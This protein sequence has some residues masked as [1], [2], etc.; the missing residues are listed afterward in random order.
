MDLPL[1]THALVTRFSCLGAECPDTCCSGWDMPTDA[2]Q[3]ALYEVQAPELLATLDKATGGMKRAANGKDCA[4]LC[5]GHCAIQTRYGADFL[6]DSC[7]FYPRIV[8]TLGTTQRMTG[9]TSCPEMLRLMMD[10]K[11]P[12]ML[13]EITLKR[14]PGIR[15]DILPKGMSAAEA[16]TMMQEYMAIAQDDTA[17]PEDIM[18]RIIAKVSSR[19]VP[20]AT[21]ATLHPIYYALALTDAF[22]DQPRNTRLNDVMMVMEAALGCQ[23]DRAAR[24]LSFAPD[25]A[26]R[27]AQL[28]ARWNI[29]AQA[30]LAPMMRRWIQGQLT[31]TAFPFGGLTNLTMIGRTAMLVQHFVTMRLALMCHVAQNAVPPDEA[32]YLR[33]MQTL[34]RFLDH[35]A[36]A[37]LTTMIHRDLG[38]T[39]AAALQALIQ[40]V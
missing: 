18:A 26:V 9:S 40:S 15:R 7:H 24:T 10:E 3:L 21:P 32:T 8:H 11:S 37:K 22:A 28:Q 38:W 36:D 35:L 39:D 16:M 30:A 33:V 23:F 1:H 17:S 34:S 14:M 27:V 19:D 2:A 29:D 13:S 25:A 5:E 4:Q 6:G 12:F 20:K 31:M